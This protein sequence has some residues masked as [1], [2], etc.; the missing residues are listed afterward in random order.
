VDVAKSSA[1][2]G[3][4]DK[5]ISRRHEKQVEEGERLEEEMWAESERRHAARQREENRAACVSTT[6]TR[7]PAIALPWRLLS[8]TTRARPRGCNEERTR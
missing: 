1:V 6:R 8:P 4:L 3:E 2:E 7:P 5:F